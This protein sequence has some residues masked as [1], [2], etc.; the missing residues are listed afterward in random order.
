MRVMPI[1]L[2]FVAR[3]AWGGH[4]E[5][6]CL[7]IVDLSEKFSETASITKSKGDKV[8]AAMSVVA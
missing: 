4:S 2:V 3:M 1:E 8:D 5:A 7:N 6:S